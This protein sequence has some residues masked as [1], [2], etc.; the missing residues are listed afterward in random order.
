MQ[1]IESGGEG[2]LIYCRMREARTMLLQGERS[3]PE[4]AEALAYRR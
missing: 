4:I 1:D 3:V 2:M